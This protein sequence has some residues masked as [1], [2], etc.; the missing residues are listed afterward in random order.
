MNNILNRGGDKGVVL[1]CQCDVGW[2]VEND[3]KE[4]LVRF[5]GVSTY[6]MNRAE[7]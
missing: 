6:G 4:G 1:L 3:S 7:S 2:E 5:F